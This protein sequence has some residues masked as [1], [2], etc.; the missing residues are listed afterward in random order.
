M[1]RQVS[2]EGE[3]EDDHGEFSAVVVDPEDL[4]EFYIEGDVTESDSRSTSSGSPRKMKRRRI[5]HLG[6]SAN[7]PHSSQTSASG[8]STYFLKPSTIPSDR[9]SSTSGNIRQERRMSNP[10]MPASSL[11]TSL[12]RARA[13]SL[14]PAEDIR[15]ATELYL[16]G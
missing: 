16:Q 7:K 2:D 12:L 15:K 11:K 5:S 9:L 3:Y 14:N 1:S 4:Q 10:V 6:F 13:Q 8:S